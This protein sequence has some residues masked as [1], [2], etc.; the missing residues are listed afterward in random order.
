LHSIY[1]KCY[2]LK[3][4]QR[5]L[6]IKEVEIKWMGALSIALAISIPKNAL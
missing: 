2:F 4:S 5:I 6:R 3:H 1:A